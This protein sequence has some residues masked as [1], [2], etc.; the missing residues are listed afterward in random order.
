MS[1]DARKRFAVSWFILNAI[2][3]LCPFNY[4]AISGNI[5]P[6]FGIPLVVFYFLATGVSVVASVIF[7]YCA[8]LSELEQ[9]L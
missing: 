3:V 7:S 1:H 6:I 9:A 8:E 2:F 4:F 5:T